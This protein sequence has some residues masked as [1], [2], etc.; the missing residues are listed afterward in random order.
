MM[1]YDK[2]QSVEENVSLMFFSL[3]WFCVY[4]AAFLGV[5]GLSIDMTTMVDIKDQTNK[6]LAMRL[7]TSIQ[8]GDVFYTDLNGFQVSHTL[9]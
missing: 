2:S 6:E 5:D 4:Y 9:S 1:Q 3:F 8:N 7:V